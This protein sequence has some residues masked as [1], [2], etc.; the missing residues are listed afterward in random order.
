MRVGVSKT[1]IAIAIWPTMCMSAPV[2]DTETIDNLGICFTPIIAKYA[3]IP[4]DKDIMD[5]G[6]NNPE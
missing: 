3:T 6:V 5:V 2:T 1:A 4:P